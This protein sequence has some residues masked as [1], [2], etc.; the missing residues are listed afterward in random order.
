MRK[1]SLY[2]VKTENHPETT[3]QLGI[4]FAISQQMESNARLIIGSL[5]NYKIPN[6]QQIKEDDFRSSSQSFTSYKPT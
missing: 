1:Q 2:L 4:T 6:K 5:S 3:D